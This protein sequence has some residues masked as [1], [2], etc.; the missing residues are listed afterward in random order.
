MALTV[1][2]SVTPFLITIPQSD[3]TLESGTKYK[4]TVDEFWVLLRDFTDEQNTMAQPKLYR[5]IPATSSTPSITE[6]E[7]LYYALQ[8]EDGMYS[9]NIINGNTNIREVEVKNQVSVNTNNTTGFIDPVFLE[10]STF[11]GGVSV[12]ESSAYSGSTYPVGTPSQPVNN[13]TDALTIAEDH[14]FTS[15]LVAGD[16]T[17]NSGNDFTDY[18]FY[19]AGQNLSEMMLDPS[20][21]LVNCSFF[22]A[23]IAGTLDGDTHVEDCIIGNLNFVSGVIERC[24]L[25]PGTI[26]L[27]GGEIAHFIDC[28]SGIPGVSSPIIDMGGAGQ[29]LAMRNYNGGITLENKTGVDSVSL[30]INSGQ[31]RLRSTVTNGTI[32][33][34]GVGK[35]VDDATGGRIYSGTWNGATI[36]NELIDSIDVQIARKSQTNSALIVENGDSTKTVTIYDDDGVTALYQI[37]IAADDLSR[38]KV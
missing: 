10:Y 6:I 13:F 31:V 32:V 1:D 30:D 35:L 5:R 3:L 7:E 16:V 23:R 18:S 28:K 33:V 9:V 22:G 25:E 36:I 4:L 24:I 21:M 29:P 20:A 11:S 19:G 27:G 12:N 34:R 17:I 14:G 26:V 15:F 8:F 38:S 37:D 2:Y